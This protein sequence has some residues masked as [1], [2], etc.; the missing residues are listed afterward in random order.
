MT[1]EFSA[2]LRRIRSGTAA[3]KVESATIEFKAPSAK[4]KDTLVNL[5]DSALPV[6]SVVVVGPRLVTQIARVTSS[7][8]WPG[9]PAPTPPASPP[10]GSSRSC[11][12][13]SS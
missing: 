12:A 4:V 13:C 5:A 6:G 3:R 10:T 9:T 7:R 2:V 8:S 1:D 11:R